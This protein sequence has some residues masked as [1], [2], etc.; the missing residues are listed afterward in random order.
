MF[1]VN[2]VVLTVT[3]LAYS[4]EIHISVHKNVQQNVWNVYR[5]SLLDC[6]DSI[7]AKG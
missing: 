2:L 3:M 6:W 7:L 5:P 4:A 1:E